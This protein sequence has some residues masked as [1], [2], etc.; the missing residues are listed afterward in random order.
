MH[1]A[2][3]PLLGLTPAL[4]ASVSLSTQ[5]Q[6]R[7]TPAAQ[8]AR[9]RRDAPTS[10]SS[11]G[12]PL[13]GRAHGPLTPGTTVPHLGAQL[14]A[15]IPG[16]PHQL[17]SGRSPWR[18]AA[19]GGGEGPSGPGTGLQGC[20]ASAGAGGA[21]RTPE[22]RRP[23]ASRERVLGSARQRGARR[24]GGGRRAHLGLLRFQYTA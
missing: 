7:G 24:A 14:R 6:D 2:Q 17:Q 23:R 10:P 19:I 13:A 21:P 12:D 1:A 3:W 5:S 8:A 4:G 18:V 9:C 22:R 15:K 11:S 20:T 16:D